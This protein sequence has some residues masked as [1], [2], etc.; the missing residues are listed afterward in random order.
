[1]AMLITYCGPLD[2][3]TTCWPKLT[4]RERKAK[5]ERLRRWTTA[6][7]RRLDAD[8]RAASAQVRSSSKRGRAGKSYAPGLSWGFAHE[9][10]GILDFGWKP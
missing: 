9:R 4:R 6:F 3:A 8:V 10:G 2:W 7:L 5:R 1:M